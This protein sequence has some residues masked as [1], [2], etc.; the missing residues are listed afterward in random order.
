MT[1]PDLMNIYC[2]VNL[3]PA[4]S[5]SVMAQL[6]HHDQQSIAWW[7]GTVKVVRDVVPMVCGHYAAAST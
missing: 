4:A 3:Q 1:A 5:E 2:F 6:D 7:V